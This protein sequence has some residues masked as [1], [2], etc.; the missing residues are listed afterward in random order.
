MSR[1]WVHAMNVSIADEPRA[2]VPRQQP[3]VR[4]AERT[5]SGRALEDEIDCRVCRL[6][7]VHHADG[8]LLV[9]CG[10]RVRTSEAIVL[11]WARL[12][13]TPTTQ[14]VE[15]LSG[16]PRSV[17][18]PRLFTGRFSL[19]ADAELEREELHSHGSAG[20]EARF[21]PHLV[22]G[23]IEP[24]GIFWDFHSADGALP[25]GADRLFFVARSSEDAGAAFEINAL[26][27]VAAV[28]GS[29]GERRENLLEL[30]PYVRAVES[31]AR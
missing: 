11:R 29:V 12:R 27:S 25:E 3:R 14:D 20:P 9:S 26:V 1:V 15:V 19:S 6:R 17:L 16:F 13:I 30:P 2:L 23:R 8:L 18:E 7:A 21:Q 10:L 5:D 22:A 31:P 4:G 24:R 28:T